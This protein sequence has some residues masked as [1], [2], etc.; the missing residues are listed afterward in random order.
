MYRSRRKT[1]F[2]VTDLQLNKQWF[3]WWIIRVVMDFWP[4][5]AH[6]VAL[7]Y[8]V[9]FMNV[10]QIWLWLFGLF[11]S[12]ILLSI[13]M[14]LSLTE[15]TFTEMDWGRGLFLRCF[16]PSFFH[17]IYSFGRQVG[18]KLIQPQS[19]ARWGVKGLSWRSGSLTILGYE[20]TMVLSDYPRL[21]G[22]FV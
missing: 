6:R 8:S 4:I 20:G 3:W 19:W 13:G 14:F 9:S 21:N 16:M 18:E 15:F 12:V 17:Y 10:Q 5:A 7:I 22:L 1:F 2:S 11:I